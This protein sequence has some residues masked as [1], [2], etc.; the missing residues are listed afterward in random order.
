[1]LV[2]RLKDLV[3]TFTPSQRN[4]SVL[5]K[6]FTETGSIDCG[7]KGE[8]EPENLLIRKASRK[9]SDNHVGKKMV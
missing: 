3:M 4:L 7:L 9:A 5:L 8:D 1:M 2:R 6:L